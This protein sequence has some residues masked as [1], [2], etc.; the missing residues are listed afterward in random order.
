MWLD[1]EVPAN[2]T[3]AALHSALDEAC[4]FESEG[5]FAFYMNN[6]FEDRVFNY[7]GDITR[8]G[9]KTANTTLDSFKLPVRKRFAY[10]AD[11]DQDFRCEITVVA[12]G[13]R[14]PDVEYPRVTASKLD[15]DELEG[16]Q[17]LPAEARA[18][19]DALA[20]RIKL[21]LDAKPNQQKNPKTAKPAS[22]KELEGE[23]ELALELLDVVDTLGIAQV[24]GYLQ[25][26]RRLDEQRIQS[27]L[28]TLDE[29]LGEAESFLLAARLDE[30][31]AAVFR[32]PEILPQVPRWLLWAGK[33]EQAKE[34]LAQ[35]LEQYPEDA[36][37]LYY[38]GLFHLDLEEATT[39]E[40][41]LREALHWVG[42]DLEEREQ[43]VAPLVDILEESG[44]TDEAQRLRDGGKKQK[45]K[46]RPTR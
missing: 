4:E 20:G 42:S 29:R 43:I 40:R 26:V 10:V 16:A 13:E 15:D 2:I 36:T 35:L 7:D 1:L 39:A 44:R 19:L 17:P 34:R 30:R 21:A 45:P 8:P 31:L 37:M 46:G 18:K 14:Q 11:V 32:A 24:F 3:L 25:G 38:A 41:H 33:E 27:W 23:A 22:K 6:R 28:A 12:Y 9:G 5:A